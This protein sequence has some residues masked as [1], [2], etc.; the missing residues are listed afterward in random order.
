MLTTSENY[1]NIVNTLINS[2]APLKQL[3]KKQRKSQQKSWITNEI[4]NAIE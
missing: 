3:N 1:L 2:H 4:Q